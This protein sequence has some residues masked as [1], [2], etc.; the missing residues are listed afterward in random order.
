MIDQAQQLAAQVGV[1][2]ACAVLT[3]PRSSFYRPPGRKAPLPAS[4][5][6]TAPP[7]ALPEAQR[8]E[9][10]AV[11]NSDE[12]CDHAP[13]QV[14]ARLLD[15][16]RYLCSWRTMYRLLDA[17]DE[18][19]ERRNQ[20][21]RPSYAKPELMATAPNQVWT[22]D[23]TKLR[24]PAKGLYFYLYVILDLFSRYVVGWMVAPRETAAL[25]EGLVETTCQR[26]GIDSDQLTL[27]A[28]RGSPMTAKS[29]SALLVDLGVVKSHSRP[30]V[31]DDNPYSEAHFK[32][33]KYRPDFPDRFGCLEDA[34]TWCR[35]F[36]Q[37]Y[38]EDHYHTGLGLLTPASIHYG[39]HQPVLDQR[40]QVLNA[41]F[42]AHPERFVQGRPTP[43]PLPEA[44]W[45]NP[46][47]EQETIAEHSSLNSSTKVSQSH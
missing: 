20:L 22:W 3:V 14:W 34:R 23:I 39:H 1:T 17:F 21:R 38:N 8:L 37:W 6:R 27:H 40:Q 28:D 36:F 4:T 16:G 35:P 19:K 12:F 11:L 26:Q 2:R 41:A 31:C 30:H 18:V 24:G 44:V 42:A 32:T 10:R 25:A 45:I 5:Q 15:Q 29:M 7:R 43:Q 33:L 9:V 46:P 13:R 47:K